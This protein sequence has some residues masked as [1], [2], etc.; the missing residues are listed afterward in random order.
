MVIGEY[1]PRAFD[2]F[3]AAVDLKSAMA[4][5]WRRLLDSGLLDERTIVVNDGSGRLVVA[6]EWPEDTRDALTGQ[7]SDFV[8]ELWSCLDSL[9]IETVSMFSVRRR[10]RNR[11]RPRF[12][13]M[14]DSVEGLA[15]LLDESCLDG[16]LTTQ[17]RIVV[18]SQP[19]WGT[20]E[21]PRIQRVRTG[22]GW[23]LD[24]RVRIDEGA[25]VSA[26]LTPVE[27]AVH[28]DPPVEVQSIDVC[29]AGE[30]VDERDVAR[31]RLHGYK[32]G[33]G[34]YG[35]VGSYVDLGFADGFEPSGV[36]DT[37]EHRTGLVIEAVTRLM[38]VFA[39]LARQV[40]GSRRLST[41]FADIRAWT[42]ATASQ[43]LWSA[44]DLSGLAASDFGV[45]IVR[46]AEHTTLLVTTEHGVF[47]RTIAPATPL[48]NH[49]DRGGA[50]ERAAQD[51]AA[52]W[53]LPDFVIAPLVEQ[54]G[55][56]VREISD[57]LL[58][59]GDQGLVVQ[60]KSRDSEPQSPDKEISWLAKKIA[61]AGRQVDGT[62]RRLSSKTTTM[63]NGRGRTINV[64]GAELTWTGVVIVDHPAIPEDLPAPMLDTRTPTVAL[65]RR[66]WEFL[67]HQ[68]RSSRAVID[69]LVRVS[70]TEVRLGH[71]PERYYELAATDARAEPGPIDPAIDGRGTVVS[72]PLLP[73]AP[74]GSDDDEAHGMVRI[75][76]EDI[77]NSD[78]DAADETRRL[79]ALAAIDQLPV[80]HRTELGQLLLTGLENARRV[81]DDQVS[82]QFR[83]YQ[84]R[85][86]VP[87]LGFG[88]CSRLDDITRAAFRSWLLLR[89]HENGTRG[90]DLDNL[91]SV[92]VL[93]TPRR[94]DYRDWDTT[95]VGIT[96][97]P[98]LTEDELRESRELWNQSA[99]HST[100]TTDARR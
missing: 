20:H 41:P 70:G 98:E 73:V 90:G 63:V 35:Q 15:A 43:R 38:A 68:L 27:P 62:V 50:A 31:F 79:R 22:L 86:P 57:G 34:V 23:L 18:D 85:R 93:L 21:D 39:E 52:T 83:I 26:W 3:H 46:D 7:F 95:M 82:W 19:F 87:Q 77:A 49:V 100:G 84:A 47:E 67:F 45:G 94:D 61:A 80:A 69:Y 12:F 10:P 78:F 56:G 36:D 60:V 16:V 89:H 11:D 14:A 58:I 97:D 75:M 13:P 59:V 17:Y 44:N 71:E 6:A 29:A 99:N 25:Q 53:G 96:G 9:V 74:A 81:N 54:K 64:T 76:C 24:W 28:V 51:A 8:N 48:N 1:F 32:P 30:L 40:P 72:A 66:D 55:R 2:H 92:G 37:F 33:M 4:D 88:V 42:D 91:T 65:A 5:M